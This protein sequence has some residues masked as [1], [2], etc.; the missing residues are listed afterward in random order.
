MSEP[1]KEDPKD[2]EKKDDEEKGALPEMPKNPFASEDNDD[3][4][5]SVPRK[6]LLETCCCCFCVCE[7]TATRNVTCCCCCPIKCGV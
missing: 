7:N 4:Y 1:K 3:D 6:E 5:E 2:E